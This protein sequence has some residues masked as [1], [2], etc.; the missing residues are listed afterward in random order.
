MS[1]LGV[2]EPLRVEDVAE[3]FRDLTAPWW[4][5]G[6]W[7]LDAFIGRQTREHGDVDV[8]VL[9]RDQAAVQEHLSAWDLQAA[10]P[11]GRLR[12]WHKGEILPEPVHDIWC[13]TSKE[14]SWGLQLMLDDAEGDEWLYRRMPSVRRSLDSL[15]WRRDGV[16]Y[17]IPEV[18][19]LYK[20]AQRSP[21]AESDFN[22]CLP[23]L[24]GSRRSWLANALAIA[25]P[26]HPWRDVLLTGTAT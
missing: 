7:A 6:G 18:Q 10:D 16:P 25:H 2:W 26:G 12:P 15:V 17:L 21:K 3:L 1:E 5:A 11:P 13:R 8:G 23:H 14:A 22:A 4:I 19:L 24:E 9:R 20:G